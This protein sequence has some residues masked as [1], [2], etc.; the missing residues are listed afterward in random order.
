MP[1]EKDWHYIISLESLDLVYPSLILEHICYLADLHLTTNCST[2]LQSTLIV[3]LPPATQ[4]DISSIFASPWEFFVNHL[5]KLLYHQLK[6]I[7]MLFLG[8][9]SCVF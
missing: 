3:S 9:Q 4:Y 5:L 1:D 7:E 2:P 6:S 8:V